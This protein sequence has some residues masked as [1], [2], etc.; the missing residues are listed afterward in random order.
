MARV[1]APMAG[2]VLLAA[3]ALSPAAAAPAADELLFVTSN[4][5]YVVEPEAGP[6]QV[7]WQVNLQ[8]NDPATAFGDSGIVYF[9]SAMPVPVLTGATNV[10][11]TGPGGASL[12]VLVAESE[13]Q[14]IETAT[15]FFDRD[16]FYGDSYDF[17]LT[18]ELANT[19]QDLVLVSEAYV[20][21][22][23]VVT[24]DDAT[25]SISA[26][27]DAPWEAT[28]EPLDC[29]GGE[30]TFSCSATDIIVAAALVEVAQPDALESRT[31]SVD[32][33]SGPIAVTIKHFPGED[34][35][36]SHIEAI[37]AAALPKLE[38]L[39]G[40]PYV[41]PRSVELSERGRRGIGGYEGTF[42]CPSS[43]EI[44]ISPVADDIIAVHE[45]AHLWT[46]EIESRWIAEGLAEFMAQRAAASLPDVIRPREQA[47]APE[48]LADMHLD[49][50]GSPSFLIGASE[51]AAARETSGYYHALAFFDEL[52]TLVGLEA[53]Q[54]A[55]AAAAAL[56]EPVDSERYLDALEE[57]TGR[58]LDDLFLG[59]VFPESK[60]APILEQRRRVRDQLGSLEE[61]A[62]AAELAMP[63]RLREHVGAWQFN[64][65]A[66]EIEE[67]E[68]AI[69]AY[70]AARERADDGRSAW[71]R[72]G[73]LG[74]DPEETLDESAE[75]FAAGDFAGATERA[76]EALNS[77]DDASGAAIRRTLVALVALLAAL[78]ALAAGLW[79]LRR[80][81]TT[82]Q[83][84]IP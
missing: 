46:E 18:Y 16:L 70:L 23:A 9:Y 83:T 61:K 59:K 78:G 81:R 29:G 76:V 72:I 63:T 44:G 48:G 62:A 77:I 79:L 14:A 3:L 52:E 41:G 68:G 34:A 32:L 33:P 75:A 84:S 25:V 45:L 24:G 71:Q 30:E 38:E 26:A 36:A 43:C 60:Y 74:E 73:L 12:D 10:Q 50:W 55:N 65:A 15:V 21:L 67:A 39:F 22:P 64:D 42:A 19:R 8:N 6:P 7:T 31:L 2:I 11:A 56:V 35:W 37:S 5:H 53:I 54:Q 1:F 58:P 66:T 69:D 82:S 27:G 13:D 51:A 57:A 47:G 28:I 40:T 80:R 4:V 20:F 49:E 17:K